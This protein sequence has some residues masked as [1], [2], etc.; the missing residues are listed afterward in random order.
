MFKEITEVEEANKYLELGLLWFAWR[1]GVKWR[2]GNKY[3]EWAPLHTSVLWTPQDF[4]H[5]KCAIQLEE[6]SS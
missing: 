4:R 3:Y 2:S 6:Y 5:F 1:N